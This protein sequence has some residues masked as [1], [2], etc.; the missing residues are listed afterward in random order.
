M[1]TGNGRRTA[2]GGVDGTR[3]I[4]GEDGGELDVDEEEVGLGVWDVAV[5]GKEFD[6]AGGRADLVGKEAPGVGGGNTKVV[7]SSELDNEVWKSGSAIGEM[8]SVSY[9]NFTFEGERPEKRRVFFPPFGELAL[10]TLVFLAGDFRGDFDCLCKIVA[11]F[12]GEVGTATGVGGKSASIIS[13]CQDLFSSKNFS[14]SA[15]KTIH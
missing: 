8:S 2:A 4:S 3:L 9:E 1:A 6:T 11:G 12:T 13:T 15:Y 7:G 5:S 10:P 14:R